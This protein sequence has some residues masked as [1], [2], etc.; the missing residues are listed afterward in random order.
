[1]GATMNNNGEMTGKGQ[2]GKSNGSGV[3]IDWVEGQG[4]VNGFPPIL[5]NDS[6]G[7]PVPGSNG[8]VAPHSRSAPPRPE[9]RETQYSQDEIH[10]IDFAVLGDGSLVELVEDPVDPWRCLLAVWK[11]GEV[12][13]LESLEE[14]GRLLVPFQ[15]SENALAHIR[16][17]S[18]AKPYGSVTELTERLRDFVQQFV[19]VPVGCQSAL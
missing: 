18:A 13:F 12:S 6:Q 9:Q 5:P 17:P 16:L 4:G 19:G 15:R 3:Y 2:F 1:M 8:S 7:S 14:D 11:D 10:E